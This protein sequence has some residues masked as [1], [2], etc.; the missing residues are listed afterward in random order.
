M[1]KAFKGLISIVFCALLSCVFLLDY[2]FAAPKKEKKSKNDKTIK[3]NNT[4]DR[5]STTTLDPVPITHLSMN[6][7]QL[8]SPEAGSK[9]SII[10]SNFR[11]ENI[12]LYWLDF[13]G[14]RV[15]YRT[16]IPGSSYEQLSYE[17]HYWLLADSSDNGIV[18]LEAVKGTTNYN[19]Y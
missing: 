3:T 7:G 5:T 15:W 12:H 13:N 4:K 11:S 16:L 10:V 17:G 8:V 6:E 18:I 2:S 9:T 14:Q 19:L 1:S